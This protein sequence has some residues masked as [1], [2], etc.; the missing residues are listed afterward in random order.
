MIRMDRL[1]QLLS[2]DLAQKKH[3]L[4]RSP[5]ECTF[6]LFCIDGLSKLLWISTFQ[7][8]KNCQS[9]IT[10]LT[11]LFRQTRRRPE[12]MKSAQEA[13]LF[14]KITQGFLTDNSIDLNQTHTGD[15]AFSSKSPFAETLIQTLKIWMN[16]GEFNA[17]QEIAQS[18]N[19]NF[20]HS[21]RKMTNHMRKPFKMK[22]NNNQKKFTKINS[23]TTNQLNQE[24]SW[25]RMILL[26]FINGKQ[27]LKKF[28]TIS[29][30]WQNVF[31]P[32]I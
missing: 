5:S 1:E 23:T 32:Y 27:C 12:N 8:K 30:N 24:T 4:P 11:V 26:E 6:K 25:K 17:I 3:K 15:V 16:R 28:V 29:Q 18:Y 10:G 20:I 2:G 7:M 22:I 31:F 21:T 14:I 19:Q 9:I 13:G